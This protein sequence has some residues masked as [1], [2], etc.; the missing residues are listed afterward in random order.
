VKNRRIAVAV[1]SAMLAL[2]VSAQAT[3]LVTNGDFSQ[4]N[5]TPGTS[6]EAGSGTTGTYGGVSVTGW[7]ISDFDILWYAPTANSASAASEYGGTQQLAASF[8]ELNNDANGDYILGIDADPTYGGPA[9]QTISGLTPNHSYVVTFDWAAT[10]LTNR[11]GT[12]S[13]QVL[14]CLTTASCSLSF[15]NQNVGTAATASNGQGTSVVTIGSQGFSGW[16]QQSFSF[17]A[18]ASSETLTFLAFGSPQ[19]QPPYAL[20]DNVSLYAVPEPASWALM[21]LGVAGVGFMAR[22]RRSLATA[23]A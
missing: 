23:A 11:S 12:T 16:M 22:R 5:I 19:G 14:V 17:T 8:T 4:S 1:G 9:S 6:A 10:Q 15:P 7:T 2:G 13:E 18:T 20:L 3:N 21:T